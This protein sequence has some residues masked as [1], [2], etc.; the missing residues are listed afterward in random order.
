MRATVTGAVE[1][2]WNLF[3]FRNFK[4]DQKVDAFSIHLEIERNIIIRNSE[5]TGLP[6]YFRLIRYMTSRCI[7]LNLNSGLFQNHEILQ[8]TKCT[9]SRRIRK[10]TAFNGQCV[11]NSVRSYATINISR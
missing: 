10:G 9:C 4:I 11:S 1:A 3:Q 2:E 6:K 7:Q 8:P 5:V